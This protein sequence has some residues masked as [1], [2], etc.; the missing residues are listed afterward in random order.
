MNRQVVAEKVCI[1]LHPEKAKENKKKRTLCHPRSQQTVGVAMA[2]AR[3]LA[4]KTK[5][6]RFEI[7]KHSNV[8]Q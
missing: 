1:S 2:G 8:Q 5:L 7:S 4:L 3:Q 6:N